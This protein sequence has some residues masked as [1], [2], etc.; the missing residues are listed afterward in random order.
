MARR[1]DKYPVGNVEAWAREVIPSCLDGPGKGW[2]ATW[3][4]VVSYRDAHGKPK[5][6]TLER[7][8][9]VRNTEEEATAAAADAALR[10]AVEKAL[11]Y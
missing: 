10:I 5:M 7:A 6:Q 9:R 2:R 1:T 3:E 11:L 4:G 8:M